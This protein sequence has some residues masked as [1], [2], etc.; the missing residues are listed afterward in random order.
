MEPALYPGDLIVYRKGADTPNNGD[1]VV[2]EHRESLVVHRV[3]AL[4]R[5]GTLKTRGDANESV[6]SEPVAA[7]DVRG[8]VLLIL[9]AGRAVHALA[10]RCD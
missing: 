7:G 5:D 4:L 9:P 8:E 3:A 10:A 2:F 6:D 1:L